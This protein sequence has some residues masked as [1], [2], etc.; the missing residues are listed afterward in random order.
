MTAKEEVQ[1]SK[2]A[3]INES[4][5]FLSKRVAELEKTNQEQVKLTF[6]LQ[7]KLN[8]ALSEKEHQRQQIAQL[9]HQLKVTN[10]MT[11]DINLRSHIQA[12]YSL[13]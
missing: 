8:L 9:K 2:D 4:K 5:L 12:T 11:A 13:G 10:E 3:A 1:M 6:N 7:N